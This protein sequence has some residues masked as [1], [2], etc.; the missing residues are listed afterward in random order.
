MKA[1]F[2]RMNIAVAQAK[3]G[4]GAVVSKVLNDSLEA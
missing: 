4:V 3:L 2:D 1:T